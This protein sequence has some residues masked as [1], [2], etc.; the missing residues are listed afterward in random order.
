M[1]TLKT[2][3]LALMLSLVAANALFAQKKNSPAQLASQQVVVMAENASTHQTLTNAY[4][5]G[6]TFDIAMYKIKDS[7]KMRLLIEKDKDQKLSIVLFDKDGG[8]LHSETIYKGTEK[9]GRSFDFSKMKDGQY[10]IEVKNGKEVVG[11]TISLSTDEV[12]QQPDRIL[13][14]TN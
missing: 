11:K 14:A 8:V 12:I 9:Y 13:V 4:P 10:T 3:A 2:S 5:E 1:K 6:R 7:V